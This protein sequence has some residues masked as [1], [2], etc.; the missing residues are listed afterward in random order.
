MIE[1]ITLSNGVR[2]VF[3]K[4]PYVRSVSVGIWVESGSR[5]EPIELNG[6]SHFIEHMVFKG[7]STKTAAEAAEILD[8]IGGQVNAFTTKEHTSFYLKTLDTHLDTGMEVLFDMFFNPRF[9]E[10]DVINERGVILEEIG[11][12]E[13]DPEDLASERFFQSV[14]QGTGLGRVIL[15]TKESLNKINGE[16]LRK[17]M[18]EHYL[19]KSTVVAVS[20]NFSKE[21][22]EY[23][24]ERFSKMK[25]QGTLERGETCYTKSITVKKKKTEQNHICI[26]FP[27]F[28]VYSKRRYDMQ[29]LSNLIGGGMSSRLF[30][31]VREQR[32]LCYSIYS[33]LS[34]H[35][36]IGLFGIGVGLSK[37]SEEEAIKVICSVL[38]GFPKD[39]LM[40]KELLRSREQIKA[41]VLMSLESTTARMNYLARSEIVYQSILQPEGI[42]AAYDA[43][44]EKNVLDAARDIFDF[45]KISLSVVGQVSN[46]EIYQRYVMT[47]C[48]T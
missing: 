4:I 38:R 2:I 45:S 41:N 5:H 14:F 29:I 35:F 42:I 11:M 32:G 24:K 21:N 16:I 23:I 39:P 40:E 8:S 1:K 34:P 48:E 19:P 18:E 20:G 6:I 22:I 3:E 10:K 15:G 43:V 44:T 26:G 30:Q 17:Y 25:G 33:F 37:N 31:K 46:E 7:T 36:D 13:D 28:D 27:A 12:Y 9:D 47:E